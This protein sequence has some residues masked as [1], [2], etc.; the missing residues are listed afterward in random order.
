MLKQF[1]EDLKKLRELRGVTLA[2][3][4]ANTRI[5]V[6]FLENLE[7]GNFEF[8]P[9]TYI[10]SFIK[11]FAR[12]IDES[13]KIMLN[14]YDKARAGFYTR[15]KFGDETENKSDEKS[16]LPTV[17]SKA[18]KK[19]EPV[20]K[21][22]IK[23]TISVNKPFKDYEDNSLSKKE[24]SDR[25]WTQKI[26]LILLILAVGAGV[27]YL[28]KYLNDTGENKNTNVK[29]K[30]FSEI[31]EDY[32]NRHSNTKISDSIRAA[33]SLKSLHSDSL[34]LLVKVTKD[35]RVKVYVDERKIIEEDLKGKDSIL[36]RAKEQFRFSSNSNQAVEL[37]LNGRYL[38]K[39]ISLTDIS[40][41]NLVI[42]KDGILNK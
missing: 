26:L 28:V 22:E 19:E 12:C 29:P 32:E 33:D 20:Y 21:E 10:R 1:G 2:E 36:I 5:N 40:I 34:S 11:E 30:T 8:Q 37:Y 25:S 41:K 23:Q 4:S 38:K 35:T 15:R 18:E 24:L 17:V 39:P 6:K 3:I 13:E 14:E 27:F 16:S 42:N 9:Q 7:E 31:S